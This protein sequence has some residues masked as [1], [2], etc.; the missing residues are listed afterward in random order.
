MIAN[1]ICEHQKVSVYHFFENCPLWK[2][3]RRK[4]NI[5]DTMEELMEKKCK[6]GKLMKETEFFKDI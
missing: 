1:T 4:Y 3:K 2:D 5:H 6:V